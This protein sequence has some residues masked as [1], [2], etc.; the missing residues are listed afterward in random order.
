MRLGFALLSGFLFALGSGCACQT[1]AAHLPASVSGIAP[2]AL[3]VSD[4]TVVSARGPVDDETVAGVRR[5]TASILVKAANARMGPA[6]GGGAVVHAHVTI[7]R[8]ARAVAL[9]RTL[10]AATPCVDAP[11]VV[12]LRP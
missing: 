5:E 11:C 1:P 6:A 9:D 3:D 2:G 10:A 12:P 8:R 7:E 4:V